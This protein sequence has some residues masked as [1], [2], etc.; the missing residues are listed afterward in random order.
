[1]A[2]RP[3]LAAL[4]IIAIVAGASWALIQS[5]LKRLVAYSSVAHMGFVLLA[6]SVA[7]PLALGGALVSMVSHGLVAGALFFLVGA[8]YERTHTRELSKLGGFGSLAP[9]WSVAFVYFSLASAGLPGLSGFPGEFVAITEGFGAWGWWLAVAGL[10]VM[11]A[12]AYNLRAVAETVFGERVSPDLM[13]DLDSR[14]SVAILVVGLL[15]LG[16]GLAPGVVV[17]SAMPVYDNI[18]SMIGRL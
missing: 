12:A 13:T 15:V 18:A 17:E 1:M 7:T 14:E 4:G 11:L 16:I 10:G 2:A 3:V 5:D 8:A 6:I 9:R